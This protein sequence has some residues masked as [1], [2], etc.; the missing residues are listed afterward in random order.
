MHGRNDHEEKGSE[1]Q[2]SRTCQ[3]GCHLDKYSLYPS[4]ASIMHSLFEL[5]NSKV[6][7][8]HDHAVMQQQQQRLTHDSLSYTE[9][10]TTTILVRLR[11]IIGSHT[12]DSV[13]CSADMWGAQQFLSRTRNRSMH[14]VSEKGVAQWWCLSLWL[15]VPHRILSRVPR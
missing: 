1:Q 9:A 8:A 4:M 13:R 10:A 12:C 3:N 2:L 14:V 5:L 15:K 7:H 6:A 11:S